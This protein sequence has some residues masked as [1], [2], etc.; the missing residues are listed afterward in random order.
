VR[1]ALQIVLLTLLVAT[2]PALGRGGGGCFEEGTAILTPAGEVPIE[3]L[4]VG[5]EV[6]GGRVAAITRV[7][8]VEYL[9]IAP[10]VHVTAEHPF[11]IAAGV[12]RTADRVFP[13]ARSV[14]ARRPAYNLLVSPGGT[15]VAAGYV[16]HNKG[17]FLPDTPIVRKTPAAI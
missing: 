7:E 12:F 8:P 14:A 1:A 6:I 3:Q 2:T 17:C 9:E 5:D 11:Q 13:S 15:F 10:G 16:V 4:R